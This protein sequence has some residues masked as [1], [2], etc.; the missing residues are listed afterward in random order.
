MSAVRKLGGSPSC[1]QCLVYTALET[2]NI[3]KRAM[4]CA[5]ANTRSFSQVLKILLDLLCSEF[6]K[7]HFYRAWEERTLR[8]GD[9]GRWQWHLRPDQGG[10][11]LILYCL[12]YCKPFHWKRRKEMTRT[13]STLATLMEAYLPTWWEWEPEM[14]TMANVEILADNK[15]D[16]LGFTDDNLHFPSKISLEIPAK[17]RPGRFSLQ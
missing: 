16:W 11:N 5:I 9:G 7:S 8:E 15:W 17:T 3:L 13:P 12:K 1:R 14:I 10:K 4:T 2:S 6:I